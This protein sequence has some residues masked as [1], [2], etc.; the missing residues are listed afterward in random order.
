M[1]AATFHEL[2]AFSGNGYCWEFC[3]TGSNPMEIEL[4]EKPT[5]INDSSRFYVLEPS[6]GHALA[7]LRNLLLPISEKWKYCTV[8]VDYYETVASGMGG[9]VP[10]GGELGGGTLGRGGADRVL[11]VAPGKDKLFLVGLKGK[12]VPPPD[13]SISLEIPGLEISLVDDKPQEVG[14]VTVNN[15]SVEFLLGTTPVGSHRSLRFKIGRVQLDNQLPWIRY[16]VLL[17][18]SKKSRGSLPM[19]AF[20]MVQLE[21]RRGRSFYP[22][23]SVR[24]SEEVQLALSEPIIWRLMEIFAQITESIHEVSS[25]SSSSHQVIADSPLRIRLLTIP[26]VDL[27][28]SFQ[29]DPL[30]RPRHKVGAI[31]SR[32][33]DLAN[34]QGASITVHGL[35]WSEIRSMRSMFNE[36]LRQAVQS[37]ILG[38]SLSLLRNFGVIGGAT[39]V[40]GMLSEGLARLTGDESTNL[41]KREREGSSQA[42]RSEITD[43]GDGLL[44]GAGAFGNSVMRGFRGLIEKPL[45][46]AKSSGVEGAVK[47]VAKGLVGVVS[48]P[49][50]GMLDAMSATAEGF[51]ATFTKDINDIVVLQRQRLPRLCSSDMNLQPIL[52]DGSARQATLEQLGQSLLWNSILRFS[53]IPAKLSENS[54]S[55]TNR[56]DSGNR[57]D[58]NTLE[59]YVEHFVLPNDYV[60]ILTT[61]RIIYLF[62]NGFANL[63]A[64]V[65][66]GHTNIAPQHVPEGNIQWSVK[67]E[68]VLALELKWASKDSN[69]P[70][71]LIV[72]R[73]ALSHNEDL[74]MAL[75]LPCFQGTPQASQ[76]KLIIGIVIKRTFQ[77]SAHADQEW[78]ERH[79]VKKSMP[80]DTSVEDL[81]FRMPCV[82]YEHKWN[83][84]PSRSPVIHF[85]RP[86]PPPGYNPVGDVATLDPE[87]P[88]QP[89]ACFR[90]DLILRPLVDQTRATDNYSEE[91]NPATSPPSEFSLVW[92]HNGSRKVTVWMPIPPRGYYAMGAIIMGNINVP[93]SDDYLCI[94]DDLTS[95]TRVFDS[96]I[97]SYDPETFG[98]GF[99]GEVSF[100][101]LQNMALRPQRWKV[102]LWPIDS[103]TR[104]FMAIRGKHRPP[105]GVAR[106]LKD[107]E[108][109]SNKGSI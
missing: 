40:L 22:F 19:I 23:V 89:V 76:I 47:G 70:D 64:A 27:S 78:A 43:L 32:I 105:D 61:Q 66:V 90:N 91:G 60:C 102:S 33:M 68:D 67:Y 36:E 45:S 85:W 11:L 107:M 37:E 29:G 51:G 101:S 13:L 97:W 48:N 25:L 26:D 6:G 55:S 56:K 3:S 57:I 39:R 53:K 96:P 34:F 15:I 28:V 80:K 98:I 104:A 46:G 82:G 84:N 9:I 88:P 17:G 44:E 14:L 99:T 108:E 73:Y 18:P 71:G 1:K 81:P 12:V 62:C 5:S 38:V 100:S 106:T 65:E 69:H 54:H 41:Y 74:P 10:I 49:V 52:R 35:E 59:G 86:I 75:L 7:S 24:I 42:S 30:D 31:I 21:G 2:S 20:S 95:P 16:P 92:R 50:S 103:S 83:T 58:R 94:R 87:E 72:H 63:E 4:V 79:R 93:N 77:E 8:C 109:S